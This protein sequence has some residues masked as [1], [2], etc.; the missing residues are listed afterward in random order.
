VVTAR[1]SDAADRF[2]WLYAL[3]ALVIAVASLPLIF[4]LPFALEQVG[5]TSPENLFFV[6]MA[7]VF[8]FGEA[9]AS[10]LAWGNSRARR[11]LTVV[12]I[13]M[14]ALFILLVV[15]GIIASSLPS[16]ALVAAAIFD[17]VISLALLFM[18]RQPHTQN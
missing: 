3:N 4:A 8:L 5:V 15:A 1:V 7:G 16:S 2:R 13:G 9:I 12:I 18:L 11:D 6:Q 17:A 10:F 14:K